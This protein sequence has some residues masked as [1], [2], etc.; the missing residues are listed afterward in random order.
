MQSVPTSTCDFLRSMLK[1]I[2]EA[3]NTRVRVYLLQC[4]EE[5]LNRLSKIDS[6]VS[7]CAQLI[8][9]YINSVLLFHKII[10][11]KL[12]YSSSSP[13]LIKQNIVQLLQNTLKLEYLFVGLTDVD[14]ALIKQFKVKTLALQLVYVVRAIVC[15]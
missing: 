9:L 13:S 8:T 14:L 11:Y 2:E 7:G 6:Q 4:A 15:R 3:P 10:E 5:D 1:G 12:W